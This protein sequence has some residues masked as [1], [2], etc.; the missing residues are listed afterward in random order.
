MI[1]MDSKFRKMLEITKEFCDMYPLTIVGYGI[2]QHPLFSSVTHRDEKTGRLTVLSPDN[3]EEQRNKVYGKMMQR[4]EK[5]P[6]IMTLMM[7]IQSPY[8]IQLLL[9]LEEYMTRKQFSIQVISIWT[10]TEFPHQNG[11]KTMVSMFDKTERRYLMTESDRQAYDSLPDLVVVYRG[12]Q[13]GAIK[14]G[15]SWTVNLRMAGWFADRFDRK[16]DI[17]VATIP[18][19]RIYAFVSGRNEDEIILNP[20]YLRCVRVLDRSEPDDEG[21]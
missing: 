17:L 21:V 11:Q 9:S 5:T 12:L 14:R 10:H 19:D 4:L 7:F 20:L 18:K 15:L 3:L 1:C 2:V 6:D 13:R 8:R 16:G